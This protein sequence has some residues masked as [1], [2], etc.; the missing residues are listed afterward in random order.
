MWSFRGSARNLPTARDGVSPRA[1]HVGYHRPPGSATERSLAGA[2]A[3]RPLAGAM[4]CMIM[5]YIYPVS[6]AGLCA[7]HRSSARR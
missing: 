4:R 1:V 6:F 7:Q 3:L 5:V 2:L